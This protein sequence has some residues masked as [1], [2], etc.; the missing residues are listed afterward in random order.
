MIVNHLKES[1]PALN[2]KAQEKEILLNR[3][4]EFLHELLGAKVP[5]KIPEKL[6]K[7]EKEF[8]EFREKVR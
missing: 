7:Y 3:K 4:L 2:V 5:K 6:K 8:D 1:I